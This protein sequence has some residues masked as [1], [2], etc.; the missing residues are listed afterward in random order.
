MSRAAGS[1]H[2]T[3]LRAAGEAGLPSESPC[4]APVMCRALHCTGATGTAECL[5][6]EAFRLVGE[7][8]ASA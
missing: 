3:P 4:S 1:T 7:V 2:T 5:P 6:Q 8:K